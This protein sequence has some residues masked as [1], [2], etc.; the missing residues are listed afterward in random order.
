MRCCA[1]PWLC[2]PVLCWVT[3]FWVTLWHLALP[4]FSVPPYWCCMLATPFC[5][6][7]LQDGAGCGG[8]RERQSVHTRWLNM[9]GICCGTS[10]SLSVGYL[11]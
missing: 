9:S 4:F 11:W 5:E 2:F 3:L 6:D 8:K 1:V 7:G 10:C